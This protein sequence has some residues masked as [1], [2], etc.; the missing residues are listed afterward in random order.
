MPSQEDD[1]WCSTLGS[2]LLL[3]FSIRGKAVLRNPFA[4][5]RQ[6][7][8][9]PRQRRFKL[10]FIAKDLA[11]GSLVQAHRTAAVPLPGHAFVFLLH[12]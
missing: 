10:P 7:D 8:G 6:Q 9:M 5:A 2:F 1:P 3:A 4:A 12:E 11:E